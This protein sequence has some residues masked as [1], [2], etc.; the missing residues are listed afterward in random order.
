MADRGASLQGSSYRA[1][2]L[3]TLRAGSVIAAPALALQYVANVPGGS[4]GFY[5]V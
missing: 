3:M 5:L 1:L 2:A 4:R